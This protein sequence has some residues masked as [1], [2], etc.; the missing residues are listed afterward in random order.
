[1]NAKGVNNLA[2]HCSYISEAR[3]MGIG[4]VEV[5]NRRLYKWNVKGI[6][7]HIMMLLTFDFT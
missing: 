4:N 2:R 7:V 6:V 5:V 3:A 1:M